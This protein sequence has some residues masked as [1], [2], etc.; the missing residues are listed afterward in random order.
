MAL[1]CIAATAA[2]IWLIISFDVFGN[3]DGWVRQFRN[4]V[5]ADTIL[6]VIALVLF[7]VLLPCFCAADFDTKNSTCSATPLSFKTAVFIWAV[8]VAIHS[9]GDHVALAELYAIIVGVETGVVAILSCAF[10]CGNNTRVS[11]ENSV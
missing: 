2:N 1:F 11:S 7:L 8:I 6:T 3:G 4:C 5:A 10:V 9:D